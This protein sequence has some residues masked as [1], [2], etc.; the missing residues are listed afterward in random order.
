MRQEKT[1]FALDIDL[2]VT[3]EMSIAEISVATG[4]SRPN[5]L[6]RTFRS[7]LGISP[8]VYRVRQRVMFR[9]R[10]PRH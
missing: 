4:F 3:T 6:F 1:Q 10:E 9:K 8:R 5:H 2:L 7:F